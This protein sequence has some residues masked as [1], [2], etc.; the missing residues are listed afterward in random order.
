MPQKT[1]K[2]PFLNGLLKDYRVAAISPSSRFLIK[3]ALAELRSPI[4]LAIE[5][6]SGDGTMTKEILKKMAPN[7]TLILIE[8]NK[9]FLPALH[10][11]HDPRISIFEGLAQDFPYH[12]Y[13][14]A[15]QKVD[16]VISSIPFS[17]LTKPEREKVCKEAYDH[18]APHGQ[19]IIFH[20][21][22]TLMKEVV[23]KY[24]GAPNVTFILWNLFPCFIIKAKK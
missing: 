7:G 12:T 20:Q 8:Q 16:V 5:Q 18:L 10:A 9:E 21:Y 3:K 6:G 2:K 1:Q 19:F 17:F 15:A 22:S 14:T 11:L 24:F 13:L 23:K 4:H